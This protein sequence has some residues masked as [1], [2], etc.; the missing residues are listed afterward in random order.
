MNQRDIDAGM[1]ALRGAALAL[2]HALGEFDLTH[3]LGEKAGDALLDAHDG[4]HA[5]VNQ[6]EDA[7]RETEP[8]E[9]LTVTPTVTRQPRAKLS[10]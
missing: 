1:A 8:R 7:L 3:A 6:L 5:A 9:P 10:E 2:T 4:I